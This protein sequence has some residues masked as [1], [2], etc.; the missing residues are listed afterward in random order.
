[1]HT[2]TRTDTCVSENAHATHRQEQSLH[3]HRK[4]HTHKTGR[5]RVPTNDVDGRSGWVCNGR[6]RKVGMHGSAH[7]V[8]DGDV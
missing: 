6:A 8:T 1:M 3:T 4:K 5:A 2:Y 7:R